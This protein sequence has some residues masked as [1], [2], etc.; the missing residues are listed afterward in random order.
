MTCL[1]PMVRADG[2]AD[3]CGQPAAGQLHNL[4]TGARYPRC[5]GHLHNLNLPPG[6]RIER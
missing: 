2:T 5:S 1:E 4:A 3:E 6:W